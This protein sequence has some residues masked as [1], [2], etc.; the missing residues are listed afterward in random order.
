[1]NKTAAVLGAGAAG[2]CAALMLKRR[3]WEVM[4]A[5]RK[6]PASETSQG[7][8]G[9]ISASSAVPLNNPGLRRN[10]ISL[11]ADKGGGLD[12][13]WQYV[14]ANISWFARFFYYA[15]AAQS[16]R[17]ARAL[18]LL[19]SRAQ[20]L[21]REW[22]AELDDNPVCRRGWI[23]AYRSARSFERGAFEREMWDGLGVS[24]E[25]LNAAETAAAPGIL[26]VFHAA[27]R[28]PSAEAAVS[29]GG[30]I[31]AY[32][33]L[34]ARAGGRFVRGEIARL[35]RRKNEWEIQFTGGKTE[36][37]AH[38]LVALGPWSKNF[39]QNI[40]IRLPM[41]YERGGH[42][43]FDMDEN[44]P[45]IVLCD[46]DGGYNAVMQNGKLRMTSG[47]HLADLESPPNAGQLDRAEEKLREAVAGAGKANGE[48]WFGARP[49]LPDSL[50]AVGRL[51]PENLWLATGGQHIGF[52]TAPAIGELAAS[53]MSGETPPVPAPP[54]A[55]SRFAI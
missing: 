15:S 41:G 36:R 55:P 17:R 30:R 48:D 13:R 44:A 24:Y 45:P 18:Y 21:H 33:E 34:F 5:D 50:P 27:V 2:V 19:I 32:A 25:I 20:K 12:W 49:T 22:A 6:P 29:P 31:R 43:H 46:M 40:N 51:K 14:A 4:L 28:L 10:I 1:M 7:N 3:G 54:F 38:A 9:I 53:L 8:A 39:L 35:E 47:V 23:K 42:R 11:L 16:K 52:M 37:A 26:P